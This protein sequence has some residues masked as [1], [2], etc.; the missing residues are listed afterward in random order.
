ML[1]HEH[2]VGSVGDDVLMLWRW[3]WAPGAET[4]E[5]AADVEEFV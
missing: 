4:S 1:C 3:E 5:A 2:Y